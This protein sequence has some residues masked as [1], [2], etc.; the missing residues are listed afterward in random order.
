VKDDVGR[1]RR[2]VQSEETSDFVS[3]SIGPKTPST[4]ILL[5]SNHQTDT[6]QFQEQPKFHTMSGQE[7][8]DL[9]LFGYG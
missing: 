9:W 7:T 8:E 2:S 6:L 4:A 1:R 5:L 3:G